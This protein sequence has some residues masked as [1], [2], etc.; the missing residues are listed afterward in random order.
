MKMRNLLLIYLLVGSSV[1]LTINNGAV[2]VNSEDAVEDEVEDD[3]D[4][5]GEETAVTEEGEEEEED[6]GGSE[7]D[8]SPGASLDADTTILFTKPVTATGSLE[9]PAGNLVELL[10]GFSNKGEQEFV[11]EAVDASFRYPM[12]FAFHI[13]NFSTIA[14]NKV[15]PPSQEATLAYSFI[16][17]ETFAGRPFGLSVNLHYRDSLSGAVYKESVYNETVQVVELEEGLDGETFF[18]YVFLAACAVLMLVAGQQLLASSV[19][20][21]G[22]GGGRRSGAGGLV[23]SLRGKG[24]GNY[25]METGTNNPNDVDYDWVPPQMLNNLSK[26][27]KQIKQ[28]PRQRKAKRSAGADD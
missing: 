2:F 12:D 13:Q 25:H 26:S 4:V 6:E 21:S 5:E 15:V 11:L 9:L 27:P 28:S 1:I 20:R 18:L 16:P 3:V 24:S 23:G 14:Y 10:I 22:G 8:A 17:S 19:G 7:G